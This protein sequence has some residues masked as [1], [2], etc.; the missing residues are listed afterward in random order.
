MATSSIVRRTGVVA[1]LVACLF[2]AACGT[3]AS[4]D[5]TGS[6]DS[7]KSSEAADLVK[8]YSAAPT[9]VGVTEPV[10]GEI[11][12]GKKVTF[13]MCGAPSCQSFVEPFKKAAAAL[14]WTADVITAG[15]T[16]DKVTEGWNLVVQNKPDAVISTGYPKAAWSSQLAK[17]KAAGIPVVECCTTDTAEDGVIFVDT[18][19]A[20]GAAGGKMQAA[21]VVAKSKGTPNAVYLN[22]PAYPIV[23]AE[24]QGFT[25]EFKRLAPEGKMDTL[26]LNVGDFGTPAMT[27]AIVGYLQ[28]HP[29]VTY[30]AAGSD[31]AY[32]GLPSALNAAG[33][34]SR[35]KAVGLSPST[36]NLNYIDTGQLETATVSFPHSEI[37]WKLMDVLARHFNNASL[38]PDEPMVPRRLLTKE[39]IEDPN[40]LSPTVADYEDEFNKLWGK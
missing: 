2:L 19:A 34:G 32:V 11:P 35:V 33:L 17:L 21:W 20:A 25:E 22:V 24:L 18:G 14:G 36:V 28:S 31:D 10:P 40:T 39:T 13:M 26:D 1:A 29:D 38:A 23:K 12:A 3:S 30:I 8:Q 16:P 15:P 4:S 6:G 5:S 27:A 9:S 37:V 7:S